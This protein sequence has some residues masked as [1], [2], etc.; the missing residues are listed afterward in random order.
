MLKKQII[1]LICAVLSAACSSP[2]RT[3]SF[4]DP[5]GQI[6]QMTFSTSADRQQPVATIGD[7]TLL[8]QQREERKLLLALNRQDQP[9]NRHIRHDIRELEL[10]EL[11]QGGFVDVYRLHSEDI[12]RRFMRNQALSVSHAV[13]FYQQNPQG[14]PRMFGV[15]SDFSLNYK[16]ALIKLNATR[17]VPD[18]AQDYTELL[19]GSARKIHSFLDKVICHQH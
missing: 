12:C 7:R 17:T 4:F 16:Q 19:Q 14:Q 9:L 11:G 6:R 8:L 10:Y 1:I 18:G 13:T 5:Q 15:I 2:N 3:L